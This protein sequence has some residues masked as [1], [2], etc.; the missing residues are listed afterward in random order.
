MKRLL[1][2]ALLALS[3]ALYGIRPAM[4]APLEVGYMPIL[5][6][7]QLFIALEQGTFPKDSGAPKLVQF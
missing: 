3:F 6:D 7:A 4:S 5:P 1:V 2:W